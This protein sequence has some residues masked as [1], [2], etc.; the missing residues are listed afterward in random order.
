V[1]STYCRSGCC[2]GSAGS[3][4]QPNI[5]VGRVD[6]DAAHAGVAHL[7]KSDL[8]RPALLVIATVREAAAALL[9]MAKTTS[10]PSIAAG[11]VEAAADLKE[12][13]GELPPLIST[14]PPDV[15]VENKAPATGQ[16]DRFRRRTDCRR[17]DHYPRQHDLPFVRQTRA[18]RIS[19]VLRTRAA[20][21]Q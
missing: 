9:K 15:Q 14:K 18:F 20:P 6:Q 4:D 2:A 3:T 13:A 8:L 19:G 16:N 10:D 17:A 7:G 1:R 21:H 11:L 12:Q 5:G